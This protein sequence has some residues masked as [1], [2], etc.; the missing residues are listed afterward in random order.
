MNKSLAAVYLSV[1]ILAASGPALA[2]RDHYRGHGHVGVGVVIDP[3]WYGGWYYPQPYYYPPYPPAVVTVP[4]EPPVYIE[5][6]DIAAP[7]AEPS[8][9][10]YYCASPPGYYPTVKQCPGGWR[11]VAPQLPGSSAPER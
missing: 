5:R 3:F 6:E 10:W 7:D 1:L 9:Y 11:A 8:A 4:T 2:D